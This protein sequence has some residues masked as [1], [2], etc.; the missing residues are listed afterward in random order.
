MSCLADQSSILTARFRG[1]EAVEVGG[2]RF[3]EKNFYSYYL[4]TWHKEVG[5]YKLISTEQITWVVIEFFE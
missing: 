1:R 2:A 4:H 5:G 3:K